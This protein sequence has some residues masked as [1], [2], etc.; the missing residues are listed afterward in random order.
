MKNTHQIEK[1]MYGWRK[2]VCKVT[3]AIVLT[4]LRLN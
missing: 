4:S 2:I 1:Q 3:I